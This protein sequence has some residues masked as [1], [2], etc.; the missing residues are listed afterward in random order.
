MRFARTFGTIVF[1]DGGELSGLAMASGKWNDP[2][3]VYYHYDIT[4]VM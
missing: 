3:V 2:C 1:F 4:H